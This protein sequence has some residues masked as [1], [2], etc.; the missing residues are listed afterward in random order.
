MA[1]DRVRGQCGTRVRYG[2]II[3]DGARAHRI[4]PRRPDGTLRFFWERTGRV[5]YFKAVNHPGVGATPF[6][7]SAMVDACRPLGFITVLEVD[8]SRVED[9]L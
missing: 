8:P 3:H 5:E 9:F 4:T 6:L 1:P 7:T 2:K